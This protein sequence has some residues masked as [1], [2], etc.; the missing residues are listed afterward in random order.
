MSTLISTTFSLATSLYGTHKIDTGIAN[1]L[2]IDMILKN[3]VLSSTSV[4]FVDG[5]MTEASKDK[6]NSL[7][8]ETPSIEYVSV[9]GHSSEA[10]DI[11]HSVKLSAWAEFWQNLGSN[12]LTLTETV[13]S[14][15]KA[16]YEY[17]NE[18]NI[19]STKIYNENRMDAYPVSTEATVEGKARN[20][21][22]DVIFYK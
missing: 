17:L 21:R 8:A 12:A 11:D 4:Y 3:K 5:E 18:H 14:R 2:T 16:V 7:L 13:N 10:Y 9:I 19:P 6:L 20:N 15:I 22:V 1:T